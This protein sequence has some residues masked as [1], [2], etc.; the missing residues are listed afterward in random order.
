MDSILYPLRVPHVKLEGAKCTREDI[1]PFPE[2]DRLGCIRIVA[3]TT[4]PDHR[5]LWQ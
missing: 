4:V 5:S 3:S 1:D 2:Q